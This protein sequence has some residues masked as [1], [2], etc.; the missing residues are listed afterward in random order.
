MA[1][2]R[3]EGSK[4]EREVAGANKRLFPNKGGPMV[5][6]GEAGSLCFPME[7]G[8]RRGPCSWGL[9]RH[10]PRSRGLRTIWPGSSRSWEKC[11]ALQ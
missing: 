8:R 9:Q 10:S 1:D 4:G 3:W 7:R 2:Q 6:D 11:L 5:A